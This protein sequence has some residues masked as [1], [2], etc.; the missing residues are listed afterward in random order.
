MRRTLLLVL[1]TSG[2]IAAAAVGVGVFVEYGKAEKA[3]RL[4]ELMN[5]RKYLLVY[6]QANAKYPDNLWEAVPEDLFRC[7]LEVAPL[8]YVAAGKPYPLEADRG[9]F[10]D[11]V[12][13]RYGFEVGW[14]EFSEHDWSFHAGE[15]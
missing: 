6:A 9:L 4:S 12:A 14:F 3:A 5:V 11:R 15:R 8:D 2:L 13:R 7:E 1:A 10:C